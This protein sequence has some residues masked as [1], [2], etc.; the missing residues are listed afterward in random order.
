MRRLLHAVVAVVLAVSVSC[1]SE[2]GASA[3]AEPRVHR[4]KSLRLAVTTPQYEFDPPPSD[5]VPPISAAQAVAELP[6]PP[7]ISSVTPILGVFTDLQSRL[8][9]GDLEFDHVLAWDIQRVG[10][11]GVPEPS[12]PPGQTVSPGPCYTHDDTMIDATTGVF[13][14]S[15][16]T[17]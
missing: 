14:E 7:Q 4:P 6:E 3:R 8:P 1:G 9:S 12:P 10:C 13:L 17:P 11:F 16:T 15:F 5:T 2:S